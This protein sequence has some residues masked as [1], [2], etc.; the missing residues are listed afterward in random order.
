MLIRWLR[1]ADGGILNEMV[2][3]RVVGHTPN[4]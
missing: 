4:R 2:E 3:M 1:R